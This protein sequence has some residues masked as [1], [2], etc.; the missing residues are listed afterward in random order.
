MRMAFVEL[1]RARNRALAEGRAVDPEL[2][3]RWERLRIRYLVDE[4]RQDIY[5]DRELRALPALELVQREQ[6]DNR[7]AAEL[8]ER[9]HKKLAI[10]ATNSGE[11]NLLAGRLDLA[12]A[13][14]QRALQHV[15]GYEPAQR[16]IDAV[17][18][19]FERLHG[20]AQQQFLQAIRKMPELRFDEAR[21]HATIAL[22]RDPELARADDVR[23][24]ARHEIALA[25]RKDAEN[26][27]SEGLYGAALMHYRRA[28]ELWP[29]LE[30]IDDQIEIMTKEVDAQWRT[31]RAALAI[32][33]DRL[34][35]ARRLLAEAFER[36]TLERGLISELLLE[37]RKR[38]GEI[39]YQRAR[40]LELQGKKEEA[41]AGY[42]ALAKDWP[43]G[44]LD[45]RTRMSALRSDLEGAER[46]L[47]AGQAA[48]EK[49]DLKEALERYE[50]AATY[51][52][53]FR[54]V[55]QRIERVRAALQDR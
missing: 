23:V 54:D 31:E 44:L 47:A 13:D 14:F 35:E 53:A 34:D 10:R 51:H 4:A 21:W 1:D 33:A 24:K 55:Q 15:Y 42:E 28:R 27:K 9:A 22:E 12:L 39:A 6:P 20:Q 49:G 36:S 38:E 18:A 50:S 41:L 46:E 30:G 17:H 16:G 37:V 26:S 40:D 45:E 11:E 48:E 25:A 32:R 52:A 7:E 29:E 43:D 3:A 5:A 19:A 2:E 8:L